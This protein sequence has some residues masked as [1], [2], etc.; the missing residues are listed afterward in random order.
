MKTPKT[1][2]E[3]III[4]F[5]NLFGIKPSNGIK[6]L[7]KKYG[8]VELLE[9]GEDSMKFRTKDG[10]IITVERKDV[11]KDFAARATELIIKKE[12]GETAFNGLKQD[13]FN[14]VNG[15][16]RSWFVTDRPTM[17][18]SVDPVVEV[19]IPHIEQWDSAMCKGHFSIDY[20]ECPLPQS[21]YK[22]YGYNSGN[23]KI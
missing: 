18:Y 5:Q 1:K 23:M 19:S 3:K 13:E 14:A 20:K 7:K 15:Y 9:K 10:G 16:H 11:P 4:F 21:A 2:T 17:D 22:R 8:V 6:R 12:G